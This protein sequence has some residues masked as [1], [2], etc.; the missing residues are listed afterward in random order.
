MHGTRLDRRVIG[1]MRGDQ[2]P[3]LRAVA[4]HCG[5][6]IAQLVVAEAAAG[7][8]GAALA[9][10]A[11]PR[12]ALIDDARTALAAVD[13]PLVILGLTPGE[14]LGA[15]LGLTAADA[16][17]AA[18]RAGASVLSLAPLP[19]ALAEAHQWGEWR[20]R[21]HLSPLLRESGVMAQAAEA[22]SLFGPV[23][24]M[25]FASRG[26][27]SQA[28]LGAR[29]FDAMS[30]IHALLGTPE[31]ID[32][33]IIPTAGHADTL[34]ML[35]GDLTANLRYAGPHAA[36]LALSDRA[37]RWF[38]GATLLGGGGCLRIDDSGFEVIAPSGETTDRSAPVPEEP[39]GPIGW[40]VPAIAETIERIFNQQAPASPP[41]DAEAVLAMCEAAML[42]AR[43]GQAESPVTMLRMNDLH[44]SG[45]H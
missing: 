44:E 18:L 37:G 40:A 42:S 22:I 24:A 20:G 27:A 17:N 35:A 4:E 34:P 31:S 2:L 29:L 7:A 26:D 1:I 5:L 21:V 33:S 6:D 15:G 10:E 25:S 43:T 30:L 13:A 36:T 32:A 38:R 11:F 16:T 14:G 12:A 45:L 3:L 19:W 8:S 9:R 39:R 23:R 41:L 28:V